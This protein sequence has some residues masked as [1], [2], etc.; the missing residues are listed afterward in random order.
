[1]KYQCIFWDKYN[2]YDIYDINENIS[3]E[4]IMR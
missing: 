3:F 4:Y 2:N 1:M